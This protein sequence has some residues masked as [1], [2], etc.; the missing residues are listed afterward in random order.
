MLE[1]DQSRK[2]NKRLIM[3]SQQESYMDLV[4]NS[5]GG[6]RQEIKE[7]QGMY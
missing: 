1:M 5:G 4:E 6:R 7:P 3:H 2:S